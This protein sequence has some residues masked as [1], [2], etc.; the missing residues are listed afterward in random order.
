M[1]E[2]SFPNPPP[3]KEFKPPVYNNSDFNHI[4]LSVPEALRSRKIWLLW[5]EEGQRGDKPTK[6]PIAPWVN[7]CGYAAV[8][9]NDPKNWTTHDVAERYLSESAGKAS[10]LG[11]ALS[12]GIVGIDLDNCF[13]DAQREKPGAQEITDRTNTYVE[14]SPSGKGL[15]LLG[16]GSILHSLNQ[17]ADGFNIEVYSAGR[18]FTFTGHQMKSGGRGEILDMQELLDW[19]YAEYDPQLIDFDELDKG[20]EEGRRNVSGIRVATYKRRI[21]WSKDEV[22]AYMQEWNKRNKPSL[23][24]QEVDR[25]V[26]SAFR[27]EKPYAFKFTN[28]PEQ[29]S[30][31]KKTNGKNGVKLTLDEVKNLP[32]CDPNHVVLN[33]IILKKVYEGESRDFILKTYLNDGE[34]E[35]EL[36]EGNRFI[37]Q[38]T[39]PSDDYFDKYGGADISFKQVF[40]ELRDLHSE[41]VYV[42]EPIF[43][44]LT[45]LGAISSYFREVFYSY[46]Y[47][48]FYSAEAACGKTTA[49]KVFTWSSFYGLVTASLTEAVV[50]RTI[51]DS[52]SVIGIDNVDH[53]FKQPDQYENLIS[54]LNSSYSRG[55]ECI[56][57]EH[58][59]NGNFYPRQF[60][61]YGIK[62]FSRVRDFP[63]QYNQLKTRCIS[64]LMQK[65]KPMKRD[66]TPEDFQEIRD[67][68]YVLRL[69]ENKRVKEAY[70]EIKNADILQGRNA[71]VFYPLLTIA[72]LVGDDD[73]Y[74]RI[75]EYARRCERESIEENMDE[76]NKI[77]IETLAVN[78]FN[79]STALI[80][81]TEAFTIAL[82]R[83]GIIKEDEQI[84]GKRMSSRLKK[85]GFRKEDKRTHNKTWYW[86]DT[87][88]VDE[89]MEQYGLKEVNQK[90]TPSIP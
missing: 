87:D 71:D 81:I 26:E 76:W 54:L 74:Q 80:D 84:S 1:N 79:G 18:Y 53:I 14:V 55:I 52:R 33:R 48:D 4:K 85:L 3:T 40:N 90:D 69:K 23:S 68:L 62:G 36:E 17:K 19:L 5:K 64:I 70:E 72:K 9:A 35:D 12:D 21:G 46:P 37:P 47:F 6:I 61:G 8:N 24:K 45:S 31:N 67:K 15:H 77:L 83:E 2:E 30:G 41:F 56:R 38:S 42:K 58:D 28:P 59:K 78:N 7:E 82:S 89:L 60:D 39:A 27:P 57:M 11:I 73:L 43:L 86:I 13:D 32:N 20:V 25:I 75:I 49:L 66:P 65:G 34:Y 44:D 51:D 50:Y 88:L 29:I 63:F 16:F 22:R 10:G